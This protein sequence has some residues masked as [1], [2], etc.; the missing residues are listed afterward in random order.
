M[1]ILLTIGKSRMGQSAFSLHAASA[2]REETGPI[3][4]EWNGS[5]AASAASINGLPAGEQWMNAAEPVE[6]KLYLRLEHELQT[7]MGRQR[8]TPP[9]FRF[10]AHDMARHRISSRGAADTRLAHQAPAVL[11]PLR[12]LASLTSS[13]VPCV[14]R[15]KSL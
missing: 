2:R 15:H 5:K 9:Q 8:G 13:R 7:A 14:R 6:G 10:D 11:I 3:F 12:A 1:S 4:G